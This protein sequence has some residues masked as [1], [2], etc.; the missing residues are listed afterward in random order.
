MRS[1]T[2]GSRCRHGLAGWLRSPS[3]PARRLRLAVGVFQVVEHVDDPSEFVSEK[4]ESFKQLPSTETGSSHLLSLGSNRYDFWRVSLAGFADHP[5]AGVGGRG[6]GAVY[7]QDARS[8]ETPVRAHSLPLD[9]LLESG[10]VGFAL[11]AAFFVLLAA[12]IWKRR[13]TLTGTAALGTLAYFSVHAAGRLDLDVPGRRDPGVPRARDRARAGRRPAAP[14][15]GRAGRRLRGA[16]RRV[17]AVRTA[18]AQRPDH[19]AR[20]RGQRPHRPTSSGRGGSIR[21]RSSPCSRRRQ[22]ADD[23][24]QAVVPLERAA[25]KEPR[26]VTV[27][28]LLGLAYLEAGRPR[29]ARAELLAARRLYP[30]S[31]EIA[32]ALE[33]TRDRASD[34]A[35]ES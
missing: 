27:R 11:L 15:P 8:T 33:K 34:R 2:T 28:Y 31:E 32:R 23:P 4:W 35:G 22:L 13:G 17:A 12:G 14:A 25:T 20:A 6:F 21:S 26:N 7:L 24:A 30:G 18:V 1:S 10:V 3:R 29:E 19:G 9:V 16:R 5:V